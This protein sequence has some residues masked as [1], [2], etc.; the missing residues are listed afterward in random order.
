MN[1]KIAIIVIAAAG[2]T[3]GC[4][5]QQRHMLAATVKDPEPAKSVTASADCTALT[6]NIRGADDGTV[7]RF[8][9]GSQPPS[10]MTVGTA[11]FVAAA[12]ISIDPYSWEATHAFEWTVDLWTDGTMART[13]GQVDCTS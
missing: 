3:V 8:G 9:I 1:S 5:S 12:S 6:Y 7:V 4:T 10:A 13:T 2:L 11:D